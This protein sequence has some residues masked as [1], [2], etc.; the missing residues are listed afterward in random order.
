MARV[1]G[2]TPAEGAVMATT[3]IPQKKVAVTINYQQVKINIDRWAE[4]ALDKALEELRR[5][6]QERA[7]VRDVFKRGRQKQ[8][9]EKVAR[10]VF[11]TGKDGSVVARKNVFHHSDK[12]RD[13]FLEQVNAQQARH[14]EVRR[15][16]ESGDDNDARKY[17]RTRGNYK[18]WQPVLGSKGARFTGE[19]RRVG[20]SDLGQFGMRNTNRYDSA[21]VKTQRGPDTYD[22]LLNSKGRRAVSRIQD[23]IDAANEDNKARGKRKLRAVQVQNI[24]EKQVGSTRK[25]VF[26][27]LGSDSPLASVRPNIKRGQ[28]TAFGALSISKT[29]AMSLG[30]RLRSEIY[31]TEVKKTG[32]KIYGD[33]VSPTFY[34][35]YQEYGT[36]RHRAQPYMRPALYEMRPRLPQ[37]FKTEVSKMRGGANG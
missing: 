22:N 18:S 7:P 11:S 21:G 26:P 28:S 1:D 33:V 20:V 15:P 2:G 24:L 10:G 14:K 36:S 16:N 6:A 27:A 25:R 34:A 35:R 23:K 32:S 30:G 13:K 3:Y 37:L 8:G 12:S 19:F 29:G 4:Q 17:L 5:K 9:A 31:R